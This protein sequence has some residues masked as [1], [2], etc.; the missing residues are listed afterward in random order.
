M[1]GEGATFKLVNDI[2][3]DRSWDNIGAIF[4][5]DAYFTSVKLFR[6]LNKR[7]IK[8]VGPINARKPKSGGDKN[9]WPLHNLESKHTTF[10]PR[11]WHRSAFSP[12]EGGGW[13]QAVVWRDSKFVKILSTVHIYNGVDATVK[14]WSRAAGCKVPVKALPVVPAYQAGMPHVDQFD[15]FVGGTGIR[16]RRCKQRYHRA[17]FMHA[18]AGV[19]VN[20]TLRL[21]MTIREDAASLKKKLTQVLLDSTTGTR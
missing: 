7:G 2:W 3:L 20:N 15:K 6:E 18:L 19:G 8:A 14:R 1:S 4:F 21:F 17:P 9:S 16:L 12:L 11:G 13:L 5:C 10:L